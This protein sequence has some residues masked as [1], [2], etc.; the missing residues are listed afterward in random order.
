MYVHVGKV[1][2]RWK[3]DP[4]VLCDCMAHPPCPCGVEGLR[5]CGFDCLMSNLFPPFI[6]PSVERCLSVILSNYLSFC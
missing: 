6:V 2:E 1:S 4:L 5:G 3:D